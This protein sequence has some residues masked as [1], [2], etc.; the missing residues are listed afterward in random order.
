MTFLRQLIIRMYLDRE[1]ILGVNELDQQRESRAKTLNYLL[2]QQ[3]LAVGLNQVI[4]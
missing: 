4:Q 2:A 3:L 1:V